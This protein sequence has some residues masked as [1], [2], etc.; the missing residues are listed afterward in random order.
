MST[1]SLILHRRTV[2]Y[3]PATKANS[4]IEIASLC[5]VTVGRLTYLDQ[6]AILAVRVFLTI[7]KTLVAQLA[8]S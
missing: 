4:L 8:W 3:Q 5:M 6:A 1:I 2:A 7:A